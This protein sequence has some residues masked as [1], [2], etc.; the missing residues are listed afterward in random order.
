[1][2]K[3]KKEHSKNGINFWE[4]LTLIFIYLKLKHEIQWG[5]GFVLLPII[6]QTILSLSCNVL[7]G[8]TGMIKGIC[9]G[10]SQ[11]RKKYSK[12]ISHEKAI[13]RYEQ[14]KSIQ[15]LASSTEE[16]ILIIKIEITKTASSRTKQL[17]ELLKEKE[18]LASLSNIDENSKKLCFRK[19]LNK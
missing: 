8:F 3:Y 5:W 15:K 14:N 6:G 12:R 11:N 9:I 13:R 10:I 4:G 1:M 19:S 18:R 17:D 7:S 2:S 16:K